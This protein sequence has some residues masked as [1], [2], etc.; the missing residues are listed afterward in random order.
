VLLV[1]LLV[2]CTIDRIYTTTTINKAIFTEH[3]T[4]FAS[5]CVVVLGTIYITAASLLTHYSYT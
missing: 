5:M 4:C 2:M 3:G 1:L